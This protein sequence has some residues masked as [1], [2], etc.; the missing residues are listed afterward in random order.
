MSGNSLAFKDDS[1]KFIIEKVGE[2]RFVSIEIFLV[3]IMMY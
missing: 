1:L 3:A 2:T